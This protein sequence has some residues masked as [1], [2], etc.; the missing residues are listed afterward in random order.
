MALP[1]A[2]LIPDLRDRPRLAPDAVGWLTIYL[3]LLFCIPSRLVFGPLASAGAPSMIFGLGSLALWAFLVIGAP[4]GSMGEA[5]PLR[6]ALGVLLVC[7]G[8]SYVLAMTRPMPSDEISPADVALLALA[9]WCGTMLLTHDRVTN[10]DRLDTLVWRVAV[11]GGL[12]A[13]LGLIQVITRQVWVDQIAIPG[14]SSSPAYGLVERGGYPRPAGTAIHPIEYGVILAMLLPIALHV[15]FHH[16]HRHAIVRWLPAAALALVIPL[17][18]SRSAYLGVT[19]A[20][21]ICFIGWTRTQRALLAGIG[22]VGV[23]AMIVI[24][25]NFVNSVTGMFTGASEDPS[26]TSRTDSFGLAFQFIQAN[27]LFGRGLGTFLPKYRILDNQYLLLLV[28]IGIVGT[29]AFLMLGVTTVVTMLRTRSQ[30]RDDASRDLAM[31]IAASVAAG[32]TCLFMFDAFSF[33]QTMGT[34]FL[35]IGIGGALRRIERSKADLASLL[36]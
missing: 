28:T 15:G 31:A 16:T 17:T 13:A 11:C 18:S 33:P 34:L 4:R 14:L 35:L 1:V 5:Q 27:P 9:S 20:L 36:R 3:A 19:I 8:V 29:L 32:F 24:A 10:R 26:V 12:I 30:L 25:P 2:G 7:V 21:V 6:I 22:V 23:L